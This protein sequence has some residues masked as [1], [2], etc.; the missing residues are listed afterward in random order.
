MTSAE[1]SSGRG[2][3]MNTNHTEVEFEFTA[4]GPAD[5]TITITPNEPEA[6]PLNSP[7]AESEEA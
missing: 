2:P 1:R 7:P 5:F 3:G 4:D 6:L